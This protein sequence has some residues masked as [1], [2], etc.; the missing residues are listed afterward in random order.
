MVMVSPLLA[1]LV[2]LGAQ[3]PA[4]DVEP[5]SITVTVTD[6]KGAPVQGLVPEEV[7]V[8]ENGTTRTLQQL[9]KDTRPLRLALLVDT[10][11]PMSTLYRLQVLDPVLRFLAKLPEGTSFAVWTTGDR[12]NKVVDF[13][14][15]VTDAGK[16]LRRAFPTGGNTVLDAI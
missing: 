11:E 1:A 13:G 10:S 2:L 15:G 6:D 8:V 16:A 14:Q 12:P 7:A 4:A 3:T 5:R 9:Q